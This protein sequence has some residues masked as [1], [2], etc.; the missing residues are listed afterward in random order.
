M[1]IGGIGRVQARSREAQIVR[2]ECRLWPKTAGRLSGSF[3]LMLPMIA[4][5]LPDFVPVFTQYA[6]D[7][8]RAAESAA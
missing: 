4:G 7:L 3:G 2:S 6:A 8:K 1:W 5:S